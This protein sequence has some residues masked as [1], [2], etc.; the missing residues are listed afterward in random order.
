MVLNHLTLLSLLQ[1]Q[2]FWLLQSVVLLKVLHELLDV[3]SIDV[4]VPVT[5]ATF[6]AAT[7]QTVEMHGNIN[8]LVCPSCGVVVMMTPALLRKLRS[9]KPVPCAKCNC[10]AI[11]CRIMLYDDAEGTCL[12]KLFFFFSSS[13]LSSSSSCSSSSFAQRIAV[14]LAVAPSWSYKV[15]SMTCGSGDCMLNRSGGISA[16]N[17][18]QILPKIKLR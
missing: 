12:C 13:S 11:R 10:G 14:I 17:S 16:L 2:L 15:G 6:L 4:T 1:L 8:Q 3:E 9:K 5:I 7:G 18:C